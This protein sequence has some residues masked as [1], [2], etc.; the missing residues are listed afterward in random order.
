MHCSGCDEKSSHINRA[1]LVEKS[2]KIGR[3]KRTDGKELA[4]KHEG[5]VSREGPVLL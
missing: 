2:K 1:G 3:E 4:L 5:D